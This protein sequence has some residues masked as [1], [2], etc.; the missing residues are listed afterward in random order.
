MNRILVIDDEPGIR[1]LFTLELSAQGY[2]VVT[3][4]DGDEA[5]QKI[6]P[7][8][9]QVALCDMNMPRMG[10][11]ETLEEIHKKDPDI[12]VIVMTGYATVDTAVN[13]MKKGAYDFVQKPFNLPEV[14]ALIS[15][16]LEKSELRRT[17]L[18]LRETKKKLE[19][20]QMQLIQ[21]EKLAGIGL[22]AAG[23]AHE[24]NNPL[25]GILGFS[26]L[27][28]EEDKLTTQ[29]REDIQTILTQS[30]RCKVI[31]QNLLQFSRRKEPKMEPVDPLTLVRTTLDLVKYEYSTAG[32]EILQR[33]PATCPMVFGDPNQLQQVLLNLLTN[34][35]QAMEN[36]GKGKLEIEV[37][38]DEDDV[39]L[40]VRDNGHG[41]P[42]EIQGKIFDPFFTT[43]PV[44]KGTGLG[45]SICYG[46]LQHHHGDIQ[47]ES[48]EGTGTTF[49]I[50]LPVYEGALAA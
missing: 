13:A 14:L 4:G 12:E 28:L 33:V 7:G 34:S 30:Q 40:R 48:T 39:V 32:V 8:Q 35:K 50:R 25:S 47:V 20:T 26:Q 21:A 43:K 17:I 46:I 11:L 41:I 42:K 10:G 45:L 24:L 38:T 22:L 29:Q 19:E 27:L 36:R 1:D 9:F 44:G 6:E 16:S 31:I 15:K 3:A 49:T 5:I 2:E 23:V 37:T 18:E